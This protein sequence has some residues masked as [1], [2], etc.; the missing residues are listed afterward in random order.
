MAGWAVE[1]SWS[2][3]GIQRKLFTKG[4]FRTDSSPASSVHYVTDEEGEEVTLVLEEDGV[5]FRVRG[6]DGLLSCDIAEDG[7]GVCGGNLSWD[8][9][10]VDALEIDPTFN[11]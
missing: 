3:Q 11:R 8:A 9:K 4:G 5:R 1:T 10:F 7:S 2:E 6:A